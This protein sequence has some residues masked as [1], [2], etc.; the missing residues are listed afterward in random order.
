MRYEVYL[1]IVFILQLVMNYCILRLTQTFMRLRTRKVRVMIA[2]V[3]GALGSCLMFL[4]VPIN[5]YL[6]LILIFMSVGALMIRIAFTVR[7]LRQYL[8]LMLT[9]FASTFLL[10]GVAQW[11]VSGLGRDVPLIVHLVVIWLIYGSLQLGIKRYRRQKNLFLPVTVVISDK[12]SR[13]QISVIALKDTGNRLREE[14]TGKAVCILEQGILHPQDGK[15]YPV[16]YHTLG[17]AHAKLD[18][19]I[20]PEMIIHTK[21]G[22]IKAEDVMVALYPGKISTK[23]AYHMILHPEYLKED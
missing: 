20:F 21:E 16:S 6:K 12:E 3:V 9:V 8:F 22:D 13:E 23:D 18:A 5:G 11:L 10:G 1:D 7:G 4:P 15:R 19:F 14:S 2:S 17:N